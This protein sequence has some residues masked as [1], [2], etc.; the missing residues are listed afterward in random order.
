MPL[1]FEGLCL[2]ERA[3]GAGNGQI[4]FCAACTLYFCLRVWMAAFP[5]EP[6]MTE[7]DAEYCFD[8]VEL[9]WLE[10]APTALLSTAQGPQSVC[11]LLFFRESLFTWAVSSCVLLWS[12]I[13][14][15][16]KLSACY[17]LGYGVAWYFLWWQKGTVKELDTVHFSVLL[18]VVSEGVL[19][20]PPLWEGEWSFL[21]HQYI[22][23][24]EHSS[25]YLWDKAPC[26]LLLDFLFIE[27]QSGL[28]WK[29]PL[30][31][32]WSTPSSLAVGGGSFH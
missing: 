15:H 11:W 16:P 19:A 6:G 12:K 22:W 23:F 10:K 27:S 32:I 18:Q 3:D 29:E 26:C 24:S 31:I 14:L 21:W 13:A 20:A 9:S 4:N 5:E 2:Q 8:W 7:G 25:R 28:G 1:A 17:L 30:K